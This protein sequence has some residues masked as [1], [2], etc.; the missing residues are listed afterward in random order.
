MPSL[1]VAKFI[2][3]WSTLAPPLAGMTGIHVGR[4]ILFD[5]LGSIF[6][7]GCFIGLGFLFS[8]QIQQ[9]GAAIVHVGGTALGLIIGLATLYIGYKYYRRRLLLSELRMARITVAELRRKQAVGEDLFILDLRSQLELEQYPFLIQGAVHLG[10]D[11][12]ENRHHE[13]PRDRDVVVYCSC[14]N[15]VTS[16]RVALQLHRNGI[17]RVRPL[18]GGIDV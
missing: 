15:E 11:D 13:I 9:I 4:F 7:G 12:I 16:A 2:P 10:L 6:F 18:L 8:N 14:P 17:A 1:V 5:T 3:G